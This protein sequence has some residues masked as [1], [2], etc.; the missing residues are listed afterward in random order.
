MNAQSNNINWFEIPA[1]NIERAKTF[2]ETIFEIEMA[3][4]EMNGMKLAFFPYEM[5]SGKAAGA[6]AQSEQHKPSMDGSILYLNGGSDLSNV[7]NRIEGAGGKVLMPK[8]KI[9]EEIGYMA[10]FL[11]TEGNRLALHSP[12]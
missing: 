4:Q 7:L 11:D 6:L 2:Y 1:D 10:F 8:T 12:N 3:Q 9:N 5:G